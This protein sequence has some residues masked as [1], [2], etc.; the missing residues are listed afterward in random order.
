M[1]RAAEEAVAAASFVSFAVSRWTTYGSRRFARITRRL[2]GRAGLIRRLGEREVT[3]LVALHS[4]ADLPL[5]GGPRS[6]QHMAVVH[7]PM[8]H[9]ALIG[10]RRGELAGMRWRAI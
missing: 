8:V 1:V 4:R 7:A 5:V 10:L 9:L 2:R 6:P 3:R